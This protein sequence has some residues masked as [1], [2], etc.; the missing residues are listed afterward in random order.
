MDNLTHSLFG[1][2]LARTPLARAGRGTTAALLIASNAP[3]IDIVATAGGA[4]KSGSSSGDDPGNAPTRLRDRDR[5][6]CGLRRAGQTNLRVRVELAH[7][8][9]KDPT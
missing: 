9:G 2:T 7:E 8:L 6:D 3:D 4:A 1:A 5:G